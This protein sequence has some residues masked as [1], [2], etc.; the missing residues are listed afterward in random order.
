M[1]VGILVQA[2]A[3]V[4]PKVPDSDFWVGIVPLQS[5]TLMLKQHVDALMKKN[6]MHTE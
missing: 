2:A 6:C 4:T 3:R 1:L 5:K